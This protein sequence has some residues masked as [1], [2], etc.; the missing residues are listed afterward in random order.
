MMTRCLLSLDLGISSIKAGLFL[1]DGTL[2]SL[3]NSEYLRL[4][5]GAFPIVEIDPED[6]WQ[7][8]KAALARVLR[9]GGISADNITALSISSHGE[10]L[11]FVDS[12][13]LPVRPAILTLDTRAEQEA[14]VLAASLGQSSVFRITGQPEIV[15]IWPATKIAWLRTHEPS[16]F[17]KVAHFLLPQGFVLHRLTGEYIDDASVLTTSLLFDIHSLTWSSELLNFAGLTADRLPSVARPGTIVGRVSQWAS[18]ETGLSRTTKVVVGGLDQLCAALAAGNIRPGILTES[19]GSVLALVA[20]TDKP[21]LGHQ[22]VAPCYPHVLPDAYSLIPWHQTG[23]LALKWFRDRFVMEGATDERDAYEKLIAEAAAAPPGADGLVVLPHLAGAQFP[24]SNP[25]ARAVF[26]GVGLGHGRGHFV[27]AILEAVAFMIRRDIEIL[28]GLGVVP[29]EIVSLGG[30]ARSE[31][32]MQIKA[33]VCQLP[34]CTLETQHAALLGA[35]ILAAVSSGFHADVCTAVRA[36]GRRGARYEP[37][38]RCGPLYDRHYATYTA[39][40][41]RVADLF[42]G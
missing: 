21:L 16:T 28:R 7:G 23:G 18:A 6:Y 13:G 36:M 17:E 29:E 1:P 15:P 41:H 9:G 25:R 5:E 26:F 39:L 42:S 12:N 31:L 35:A 19:T 32:W 2:L 40:Y 33:D 27:R 37:C 11:F 20:T 8:I 34:F 3:E 4:P 14:N 10:T 38:A 24:E 30:G 22:W